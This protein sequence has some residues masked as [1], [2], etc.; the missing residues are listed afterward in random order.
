MRIL[1]WAYDAD[2]F[3]CNS[4]NCCVDNFF[5]AIYFLLLYSLTISS[6]IRSC[7]TFFHIALNVCAITSPSCESPNAKVIYVLPNIFFAPV[8]TFFVANFRSATVITSLLIINLFLL[9]SKSYQKSLEMSRP[10]DL[11]WFVYNLPHH[12]TQS[13]YIS[14]RGGG[15]SIHQKHKP[16]SLKFFL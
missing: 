4:I 5:I 9:L 16:L 13:I 1:E 12:S 6:N 3:F 7:P 14:T 10:Q 11:V 15:V 8:L 2:S